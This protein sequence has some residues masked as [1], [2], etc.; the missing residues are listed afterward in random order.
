MQATGQMAPFAT[1]T[2]A[3]QI[4]EARLHADGASF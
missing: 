1:L 4:L 2:Y 3:L